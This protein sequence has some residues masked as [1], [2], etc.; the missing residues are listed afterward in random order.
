M[1]ATKTEHIQKQVKYSNNTAPFFYSIFVLLPLVLIGGRVI[2]GGIWGG[3]LVV[4]GK[5]AIFVN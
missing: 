4:W 3:D 2:F 1:A 5:L